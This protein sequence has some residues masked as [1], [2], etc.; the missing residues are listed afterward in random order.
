M[1]DYLAV[2]KVVNTH[3]IKGELKVM[4]LTS[5]LSRFDYLKFVNVN[6][7]GELKE[8]R[9]TGARLHKNAVLIKL[10]GIDTMN[11]AEKFKGHDLWVERKHA[12]ILDEDEYFIC[13]IIGLNVYEDNVFIG[14]VSD[15]LETG[16]NDVY[17]I[18]SDSG[19]KDLL[20]PAL[21]SVVLSIDIEGKRMDVK[22]PEGLRDDL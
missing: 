6:L 14:T 17:V 10:K 22:V 1:N 7:D 11:D 3:G 15:V 4:P 2:G 5:D 12:R 20:L 16:S 13:D 19:K 18:K 9:V 21:K 8:F